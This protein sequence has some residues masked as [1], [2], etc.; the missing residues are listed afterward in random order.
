M[1]AQHIVRSYDKELKFLSKKIISMG[2]YAQN[3]IK[4]STRAIIDDDKSLA[5][6]VIEDDK[7]LDKLEREINEKAISLIAKRQPMAIDL[8]EI[9]GAIRISSDIER[10]GDMAKSIAKRVEILSILPKLSGINHSLENF[11]NLAS[12]QVEDIF[13]CYT[14]QDVSRLDEIRDRDDQLDSMYT[15]LFRELLTYMIEDQKNITLCTHLL[16]CAKNIERI[17][18]HVTNIAEALYFIV[19]GDYMDSDRPKDDLSHGVGNLPNNI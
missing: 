2:E 16:F 11:S 12:K 18:D 4:E 10:I 17:G 8:R 6:K 13:N 19:T 1:A 7:L 15:S 14:A 5:I 3:M 9:I